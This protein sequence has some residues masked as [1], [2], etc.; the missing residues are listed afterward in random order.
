MN[1]RCFLQ[2][3][4][5][6]PLLD[7]VLSTKVSAQPPQPPIQES[8]TMTTTK[9][10]LIAADP[11]AVALKEA[12]SAHLREKGYD[13]LDLGATPEKEIP[14]FE[15]APN[16]CKTIQS[17][18]A[19]QAILLCGTGMGMSIVAN[20]FKGIVAAVVESVF[21]AKMSRVINNANVLCLGAM[22]WGDWM[23]K[24]AVDAFLTTKFTEGLEPLADFLKDAEKKVEAIRDKKEPSS[25]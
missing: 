7:G 25:K 24:E 8:P 21:A 10:I 13:V 3:T 14:Y 9:P 16:V 6:V 2:S 15:S 12:L 20:R 4:L 22:I 11:F 18:K 23:A 19:D 1:R 5:A 17:G